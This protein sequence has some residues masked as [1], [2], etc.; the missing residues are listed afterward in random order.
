MK[1]VTIEALAEKIH[2]L[3]LRK[4]WGT[5]SLNG[6]FNLEVYKMLLATM[7]AEPVYQV[8][9]TVEKDENG[10]VTKLEWVDV[11]YDVAVRAWDEF[12]L[13]TRTLYKLPPA[14]RRFTTKATC[15]QKEV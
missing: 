6:E 3:E 12:G 15:V 13:L 5:I 8:E 11:P 14:T 2:E 1:Q 7:G 10:Q 4:A 9:G